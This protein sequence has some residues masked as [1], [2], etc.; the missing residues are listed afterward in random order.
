MLNKSSTVRVFFGI[1]VPDELALDCQKKILKQHPNLKNEV[2]WTRHGNHH[3][4]VR[5]LGNVPEQK[6]NKLIDAT[7][8]EIKNLT[9]FE[10]KLRYI[11]L[12]PT[13]HGKFGAITIEP[14]TE[15]QTLYDRID[16]I[17]TSEGA[18]PEHRDYMPHITL[19]RL[20][21]KQSIEMNKIPL[22]NNTLKVNGLILY[23]SIL[24]E[25]GSLYTPIHKFSL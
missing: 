22:G 25:G 23:Q 7:H 10:V 4:T 9:P 12:F 5:F 6:I 1:P 19:F 15:L 8:S 24:I 11:N 21:N 2:R 16:L 18:K 14:C 17:A 13:Y 20:R 3:I